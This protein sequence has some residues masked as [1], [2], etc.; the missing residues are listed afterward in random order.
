SCSDLFSART[1]LRKRLAQFLHLPPQ[2]VRLV[3]ERDRKYIVPLSILM[4]RHFTLLKRVTKRSG[5]SAKPVC[6]LA[7]GGKDIVNVLLHI[8]VDECCEDAMRS[9]GIRIAIPHGHQS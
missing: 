9:L 8:R 5:L 1:N 6:S 7:G 4:K 2:H 3:V